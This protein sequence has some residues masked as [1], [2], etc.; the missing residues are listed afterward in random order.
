MSS[1]IP[2]PPERPAA[3]EPSPDALIA[4]LLEIERHIDGSGWDQPPR[5][6]ALVSTQRLLAAE[7]GLA[8]RLGPP[9]STGSAAPADSAADSEPDPD[10]DDRLTAVE[11][12]HFVPTDDLVGDL[13]SLSWP[14]TVDG[15]AVAVERLFL[16]AGTEIELP[17]DPAA[18]AEAVAAH[19]QRQEV[20]VVVGVDRRGSR[21]GVAR[22]RSQPNELLGATELVPGLAEMLAHTLA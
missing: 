7:P 21:H 10:E 9:G 15:C 20:R 16:P 18:A 11:Q 2:P 6:F 3:A 4:A 14:P 19:P 5:L 13:G 8:D 22:V 17:D 1:E 12:E